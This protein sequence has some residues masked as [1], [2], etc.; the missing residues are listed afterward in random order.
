MET[1]TERREKYTQEVFEQIYSAG[2]SMADIK[3][4]ALLLI[5][6]ADYQVKN[7]TIGGLGNGHLVK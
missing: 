3:E 7:N 2:Y 4:I 6:K 1:T 5:E